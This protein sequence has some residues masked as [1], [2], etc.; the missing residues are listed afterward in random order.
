MKVRRDNLRRGLGTNT[1]VILSVTLLIL[2][3]SAQITFVQEAETRFLAGSQAFS[4]ISRITETDCSNGIDD[5]GDGLID[6]AD[7]EDC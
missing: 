5:D 7:I 1:F 6:A 2:L 4:N 3:T